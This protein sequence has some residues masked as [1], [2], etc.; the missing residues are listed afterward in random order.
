MRRD[1]GL[2]P[3]SGPVRGLLPLL[4]A[5]AL[6]LGAAS[7][8]PVLGQILVGGVTDV[9]TDRSVPDAAVRVLGRDG[10]VRIAT[11]TNGAGRYFLRLDRLSPDDLLVVEALG[12]Q[13]QHV[14]LGDLPSFS[15]TGMELD[16][17]LPPDPLAVEGVIAAVRGE[18]LIRSLVISGFYDRQRTNF[19]GFR[20]VEEVDR[21]RAR[22]ASDLLRGIQGVKLLPANG[23]WLEPILRR[24]NSSGGT[25]ACLPAVYLDG[26]MVYSS[27]SQLPPQYGGRYGRCGVILL[28]TR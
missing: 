26:A 4:L 11:S 3:G 27:P 16:V 15:P 14:P 6:L 7:P 19:G 1:P 21:N 12:Y 20:I 8:A 13:T 23:P 24:M 10:S 28:W 5:P 2:D 17:A 18:P 25:P 22:V 9:E